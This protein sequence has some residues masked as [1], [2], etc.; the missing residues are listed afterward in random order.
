MP[1]H[2]THGFYYFINKVKSPDI[3]TAVI[4]IVYIT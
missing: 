4:H 2:Y 1:T 3:I